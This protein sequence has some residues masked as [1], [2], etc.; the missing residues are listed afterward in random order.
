MVF[1]TSHK[2]CWCFQ[3]LTFVKAR[4]LATTQRLS[5]NLYRVHFA[6]LHRRIKLLMNTCACSASV[7]AEPGLDSKVARCSAA[8][9]LASALP[10][11]TTTIL[12]TFPSLTKRVAFS[13]E[14]ERNCASQCTSS[15]RVVQILRPLFASLHSYDSAAATHGALL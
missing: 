9:S 6:L 15:E 14:R 2:F 10:G 13:I 5:F 1:S 3:C 12:A 7:S 4:T 8:S 11:S